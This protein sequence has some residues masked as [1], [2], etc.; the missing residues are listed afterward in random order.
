MSKEVVNGACLAIIVLA[1]FVHCSAT[2]NWFTWAHIVPYLATV[3][4]L[5]GCYDVTY[6]RYN[7]IAHVCHQ[8]SCLA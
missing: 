4:E 6:R 8:I 3:D 1:V 7:I 5:K 2:L